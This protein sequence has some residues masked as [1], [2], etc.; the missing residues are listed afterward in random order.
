MSSSM[1]S[2]LTVPSNR[3]ARGGFLA[4]TNFSF[5]IVHP[6]LCE[7][8]SHFAVAR[9]ASWLL[10]QEFLGLAR[11][12]VLQGS[13]AFSSLLTASS[14]TNLRINPGY[15]LHHLAADSA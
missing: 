5:S 13:H 3:G 4:L 11:I 10:R 12:L 9:S 6:V 7:A 8:L 14:S 2:G 15:L 1:F